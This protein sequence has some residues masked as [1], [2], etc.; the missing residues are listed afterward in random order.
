MRD[1]KQRLHPRNRHKGEYD[2]G[3]MQEAY[4]PLAKFV[5]PNKFGSA[6]INFF[7]PN[8]VRALNHS[9][10]ALYYNIE[11]W[12]FPTSALTPPLPGRADYI[13]SLADIIGS[14]FDPNVRCLDIGVGASCIYP[15]IGHCE[16]GWQMVGSDISEASV[17][18]SRSIVEHNPCL[19]GN[20]EI[21]HQQNIGSIFEGIIAPDE[22]F[23]A[24]LCNPPFHASAQDAE[25]GTRRKLSN[26][27]GK[28]KT[29]E[30]TP[31][32]NFAGQ[33]NELWCE[34][35][36]RGFIERMIL[37]SRDF[38]KNVDYFSTLVSAEDNLPH[39]YAALKRARVASYQTVDMAQGNKRSRILVWRY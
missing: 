11:N 21:R 35:G 10:L 27:R 34:G 33:E 7:D 37:E 13:H 22:H 15:I 39:L 14:D 25:R 5:G 16:Y 18:S 31:Q 17:E 4:P 24:T 19:R 38:C 6:S 9:L 28:G 23:R 20:I 12:D 2:F 36:E 30:R 32:L 1:E 8:A 29:K 3:A 26:L